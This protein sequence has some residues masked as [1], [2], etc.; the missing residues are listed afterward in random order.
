MGSKVKKKSDGYGYKYADL[1]AVTEYIESVSGGYF[2]YTKT[3]E[4]DHKTYIWTHRFKD[5][6]LAED[7]DIR[8][9]QVVD[10]TISNGKQ[11]PAQA[12]GSALTYARRYSLYMVYGLACIDDDAE[13]LTVPD[14][15]DQIA[16][17][18]PEPQGRRKGTRTEIVAYCKEHGL[19]VYTIS[20]Q[21]G[22]TKGLSEDVLKAKLEMIK[23]DHGE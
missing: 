5:D 16:A 8:G 22:I 21:Y 3:D 23:Q 12:N 18:F 13:S 11:N 14:N 10:A 17:D 19:D 15:A 7:I 1:E 20:E 2:Q 4:I 9:A 6:L